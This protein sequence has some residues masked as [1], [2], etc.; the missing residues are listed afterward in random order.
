MRVAITILLGMRDPTLEKAF[1]IFFFR[2]KKETAVF[3]FACALKLKFQ[4]LVF[5]FNYLFFPLYSNERL[6]Y[7]ASTNFIVRREV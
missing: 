4:F 2:K 7:Y 3:S 1:Q 5:I 6:C